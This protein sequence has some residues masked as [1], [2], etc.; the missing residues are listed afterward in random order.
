MT[1]LREGSA[2]SP[3]GDDRR[4][5]RSSWRLLL[6]ILLLAAL[7]A[8]NDNG[9]RA[10]R[11]LLQIPLPALALLLG[12]SLA[13]NWASMLKWRLILREQGATLPRMALMRMYLAGKFAS[14][15]MP[16]MVGGDLARIALLNRELHN[17]SRAIASVLLERLTG[18]A[19]LVVLVVAAGLFDARTLQRPWAV[20]AVAGA[21]FACLAAFAL[22]W[23]PAARRWLSSRLPAVP[24]VQSALA[25]LRTL[26]AELSSFPDRTRLVAGTLLYSCLF[27]LICS[28]SVYVG[29]RAVGL[30]PSYTS[31]AL[32]TPAIYLLS[33][34]PVSTNN[35]G[36]WEAC[37]SLVLTHA[38]AEPAQGLAVGLMLRVVT[39]LVSLLG[40]VWM[41]LQPGPGQ[42]RPR[43]GP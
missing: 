40:G 31:I 9:A 36:W 42:L 24:A 7:L 27:Y 28:L 19:T 23:S 6:G 21:G 13:A 34:L 14:N 32:L 4:G 30:E 20:V 3:P 22:I 41:I 16:G 17:G 25:R 18:L 8:W 2:A 12:L 33:A 29:T 38:G 1:E 39:L 5:S 11:M 15:F 26:Q 35:I 43:A 37:F 10:L